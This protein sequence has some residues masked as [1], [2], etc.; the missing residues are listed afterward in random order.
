MSV[1][2][3]QGSPYYYADFRVRGVRVYESTGC[4]TEREAKAEERRLREK[5]LAELKERTPGVGLTLDQAFGKYWREHAEQ[6]LSPTWRAEVDRYSAQILA[7]VDKDMLVEEVS[8]AT[9]DAFV[10]ERIKAGAG[11]YAINRALAVWRR[12]HNLCHKRWKQKTQTIDWG[13]FFNRERKRVRAL[14]AAEAIA[15]MAPPTPLRLAQ[16]IRWSLLTGCRR[17]ETY[18]LTWDRVDLI[19]CRATVI[20]K[21]GREHTVWLSP[22]VVALLSGIERRGRYVFDR[23]NWRREFTAA[24]AR[25]KL[26]DFR[27][28]DLRHT[29]ATWLREAGAPVEVVQRAMG[30]KALSTTMR[31]AHVFDPEVREAMRRL[32]SFS[33]SPTNIVPF[34]QIKTTA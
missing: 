8:D 27:W 3:R 29:F 21:G 5:K 13:E 22:E 4:T 32:P 31:Y 16:A 15:L 34:S 10:Q 2:R 9:I 14:T 11:D 25:A 23:T 19:E 24:V 33:P 26:Q 18:G 7:I 28:H 12:V 20:A 6:K 30:H 1:Y 17:A